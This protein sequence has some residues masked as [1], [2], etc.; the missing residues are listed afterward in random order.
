MAC[1]GSFVEEAQKLLDAREVQLAEFEAMRCIY[2]SDF[3]THSS[4]N[5]NKIAEAV[6]QADAVDK[7]KDFSHLLLR[8]SFH[9]QADGDE[10][11]HTSESKAVASGELH[12]TLPSNYPHA[13]PS[14]S[15]QN[16][17][18]ERSATSALQ[19]SCRDFVDAEHQ[20]GFELLMQLGMHC[21]EQLQKL[22]QAASTAAAEAAGATTSAAATA[23]VIG[24]AVVWFHHIKSSKKKASI[25]AWSSELNTRGF[26]KPGYPGVLFVEGEKGDVDELLRRMRAQRWKAMAVRAEEWGEVPLHSSLHEAAL[27]K[28]PCG[29]D[30]NAGIEFLGEGDMGEA[31]SRFEAMGLGDL[32]KRAVLKMKHVGGHEGGATTGGDSDSE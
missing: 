5:E 3:V 27:Y 10:S 2:G 13:P 22:G 7:I 12:V 26:A 25:A 1:D 19:K 9:L 20:P 14:V 24:R 31:A 21:Q 23:H 29:W 17:S 18:L 32:F 16:C 28:S 15:I 4:A 8:C 6:N 11:T 30:G